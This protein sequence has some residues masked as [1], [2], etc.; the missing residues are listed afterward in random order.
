MFQTRMSPQNLTRPPYWYIIRTFQIL[1]NSLY[2]VCVAFRCFWQAVCQ[3]P[4]WLLGI[5]Q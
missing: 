3:S 5:P 4:H 2:R 1:D